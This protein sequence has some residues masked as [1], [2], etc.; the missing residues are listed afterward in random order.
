MMKDFKFHTNCTD[1]LFSRVVPNLFVRK[2]TPNVLV[3]FP[4]PSTLDK[5]SL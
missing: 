4:F 5:D 1:L 2:L 3:R